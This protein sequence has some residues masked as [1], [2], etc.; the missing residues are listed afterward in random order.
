[1]PYHHHHL[2][3]ATISATPLGEATIATA[4]GGA[5]YGVSNLRR[6]MPQIEK[7]EQRFMNKKPGKNWK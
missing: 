2:T 6:I 7:D 1:V 4:H 3:A 5:T